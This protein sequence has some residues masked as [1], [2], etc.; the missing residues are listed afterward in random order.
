MV[1]KINIP[2]NPSNGR[3]RGFAFVEF[4]SKNSALKAVSTLN[5]T[6]FKGRQIGVA[7]SVDKRRYDGDQENGEE[8]AEESVEELEVKETEDDKKQNEDKQEEEEEPEKPEKP[9]PKKQS[10]KGTIFL[11]NV[12]FD[13]DEDYLYKHFKSLS[14]VV[15]AKT[16]RSEEDPSKHKGSA[17]VKF[18]N[19]AVAK[20][21]IKMSAEINE[22]PEDKVLIDPKNILEINNR[23]LMVLPTLS[24]EEVE[25]TVQERNPAKI[26]G[27]KKKKLGLNDLIQLDRKNRRNFNLALEGLSVTDDNVLANN[28]TETQKRSRHLVS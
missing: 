28:D 1:N 8:K 4:K 15:W 24:R 13:I 11:R 22:R 19:P 7:L 25:Q 3:V 9:E 5:D 17:F 21:L 16:C 2:V 18:K 12:D 14:A 10:N 23:Q 26:K 6:M 27:K 20:K